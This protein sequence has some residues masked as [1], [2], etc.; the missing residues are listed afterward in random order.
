MFLLF[1]F[2]EMMMDIKCSSDMLTCA[3]WSISFFFL[4]VQMCKYACKLYI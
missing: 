2:K 1:H 3:Y 4:N